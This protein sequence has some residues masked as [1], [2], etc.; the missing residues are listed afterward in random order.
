V[1][2][3]MLGHPS[4]GKTT[5]MASMYSR[6]SSGVGGFRLHARQPDVHLELV[7]MANGIRK[8]QYPLPT[9]RRAEYHFTLYHRSQRHDMLDFAW[10]DHR[11]GAVD[12][13]T[14]ESDVKAL[15]R[16]LQAADGLVVF[17]DA[18]AMVGG[19][20][21]NR[22]IDT[23]AYMMQ[24]AIEVMNRAMPVVLLFTKTDLVPAVPPEVT[25]AIRPIW[26]ALQANEHVEA[27]VITTASGRR[28]VRVVDPV[29]F[30]LNV[31]LRAKI[32]THEREIQQ[33][34]Q[35]SKRERAQGS[36]W[37][38]LR[39]A[40]SKQLSH[41]QQAQA[42]HRQAVAETKKLRSFSSRANKLQARVSR[43]DVNGIGV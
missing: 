8:G 25:Q 21:I 33:L 9:D 10:T 41:N 38:D 26:M 3:V 40:F 39:F 18:S 4:S 32:A 35:E 5:Y 28:S 12:G 15:V 43:F 20:D 17:V 13:R 36:V 11:G 29:L 22:Q 23:L 7:R 16:D 37:N 19:V 42:L 30:S 2:I 31:G 14:S 27:A 34:E 6:L 1:K 24:G